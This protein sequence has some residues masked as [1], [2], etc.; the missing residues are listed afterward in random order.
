MPLTKECG[1]TNE[2]RV[3]DDVAVNALAGAMRGAV[4]ALVLALLPA[5]RCASPEC[6]DGMDV[7][8]VIGYDIEGAVV[9]NTKLEAV[10]WRRFEA[11]LAERGVR[12]S[13]GLAHCG[14]VRGL[15][16]TANVSRGELLLHVPKRLLLDEAY[17][18]GSEV[19]KLWTAPQAGEAPRA[20][21]TRLPLHIKFALLVLHEVRLED[22]A[23]LQPYIQLLPTADDFAYDGDPAWVW[24]AEDLAVTECAKLIEDAAAKRKAYEAL[25]LLQTATLAERWR[26]QGM[27]GLPPSRDELAWAVSV[28]TSRWVGSR[29]VPIY[30]MANHGVIANARHGFMQD[31]S[32]AML[33]HE[34]ISEGSEVLVDYSAGLGGRSQMPSFTQL[35]MYGFVAMEPA[36]DGADATPSPEAIFVNVEPLIAAAAAPQPLASDSLELLE[37]QARAGLL[38]RNNS[39]QI[40]VLQMAGE[41]LLNA[42]RAMGAA[43]ALPAELSPSRRSAEEAYAR[44][45]Q[46]SLDGFSTSL[47]A[48]EDVL[49]REGDHMPIRRHVALKFRV[50]QK[51]GLHTALHALS[52]TSTV[53]PREEPE[54][55]K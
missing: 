52:T 51:R 39:G 53:L 26:T 15:R 37:Q 48:D 42:L 22:E 44:L 36:A 13:V 47:H 21:E 28:V 1:A 11:L 46:L 5:G 17:V 30:E 19:A 3:N 31:G 38:M 41:R 10:R 54:T 24:S 43:G 35:M 34:D 40:A 18:D 8:D 25:P 14:G 6:T 23:S 45:L 16:A 7:L 12:S 33:A 27:P 20:V 4:A 29:L 49:E 2:K 50:V 9:T 55:P 32:F